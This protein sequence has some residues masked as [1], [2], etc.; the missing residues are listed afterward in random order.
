MAKGG[1]FEGEVSKEFSLY[2]THMKTD[3]GVWRTEGSGGRVTCKAKAN[4]LTRMDQWGDITYT[5]PETKF[6]F[7]VFSIECKTGYAKKTKDK[8][9]TKT[10][11]TH[12]SL[13]DM[14]DSSQQLCQFHEF[15]EQCLND[16][17]ESKREPML[18]FRRNRRSKCIAMHNDIFS[19]FINGF[20][21]PSVNYLTLN[22]MFDPIPITIMNLDHF[23]DWTEQ[24][25]ETIIRKYIIKKLLVRIRKEY[26]KYHEKKRS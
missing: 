8:T 9:K 25:N 21:N 3:D 7:D 6:W 17:I 19:G 15:W 11:L 24:I 12:W 2:L 1:N 5:I 4:M 16:A 26:N 13:L 10:T 14:I 22:T 23:F 20:G 18:V